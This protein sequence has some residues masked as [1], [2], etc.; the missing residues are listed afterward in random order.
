MASEDA[1]EPQDH[2][3]TGQDAETD[4]D[5]A[6]ADASGIVAVD[7]EGLRGPEHDDGEE[8]C[9]GDEGDDESEAEDSGFLL[10]PVGEHGVRGS[11]HFPEEETRDEKSAE[12]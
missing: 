3:G 1:E 2:T 9:A 6:D 10:Q 5:T 4:G 8:V 12:D 11:V 7:V